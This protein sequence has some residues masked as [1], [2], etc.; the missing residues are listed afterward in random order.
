MQR[1]ARAL[2]RKHA[3]IEQCG[4][5]AASLSISSPSD[6]V[7]LAPGQLATMEDRLEN[8]PRLR[9]KRAE[10]DFFVCPDKDPCAQAIGLHEVLHEAH[11]IDADSEEEARELRERLLA[12]SAA[13]IEIIPACAIA[14]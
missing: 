4:E 2:R 9:G 6:G 1:G 14:V 7:N 11:L 3:P 8:T 5:N 13:S 10:G 12:E